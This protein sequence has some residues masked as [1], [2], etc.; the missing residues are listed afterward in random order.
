MTHSDNV[1]LALQKAGISRD[2]VRK[3]LPEWWTEELLSDPS[4]ETELELHLS[5]M[6][7]LKISDL[8]LDR[9][10]LSFDLKGRTRY[11]RAKS[12]KPDE[13]EPATAMIHSLAKA[14]AAAVKMPFKPLPTDPLEVRRVILEGPAKYVSLR[15]V[16]NFL[17]SHGIPV[18]HVREMPEGM[19]KMDGMCLRVGE[20]PVILISKQTTLHAW[21]LFIVAHELAHCALNHIGN[22]EILVDH[23]LS[24]D[25]YILAD[26]DMEEI[27]SDRFA[28]ALLNGA[29]DVQYTSTIQPNPNELIDAA[30]RRQAE[31]KVDAGHVILNYGY[32]NNAWA[33]AIAALKKLDLTDAR[34]AINDLLFKHLDLKALPASS[35]EYL[36]KVTGV[37]KVAE[38]EV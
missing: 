12:V 28:I 7:G 29:Y 3:M 18:V 13:L 25:S 23:S 5:R 34:S 19:K 27:S 9:P 33:V 20:R 35:V 8:A 16:L 11:K 1:L 21:N 30:L 14:I 15:A 4:V 2:Y 26:S 32:R 36:M 31:S 24:E 6:F 37:L 22:D 10:R 38:A 17:W